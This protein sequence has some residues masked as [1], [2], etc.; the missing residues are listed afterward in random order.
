MPLCGGSIMSIKKDY[1]LDGL[2]CA[3]C[4]NKVEENV[5]KNSTDKR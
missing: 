5:K 3:N 4:A 2:D 1:I